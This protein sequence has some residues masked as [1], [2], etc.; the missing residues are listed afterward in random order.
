LH[1]IYTGF[2]CEGW[3]FFYKVCLAI[4]L[5]HKETLM[6]VGDASDMLVLFSATNE[7]KNEY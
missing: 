4:I 3:N 1:L 7:Q 2:I 5:Y 6:E